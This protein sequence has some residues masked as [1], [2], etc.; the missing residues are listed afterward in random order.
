MA[1]N[2]EFVE[3]VYEQFSELEHIPYRKMFVEYVFYYNRKIFGNIYD[4]GSIIKIIASD[5]KLVPEYKME[6]SSGGE[7]LVF[8]A[9]NLDNKKFLKRL[10]IETCSKANLIK[11]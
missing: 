3:F 9:K 2:S 8:L 1:L 6:P 7:K 11:V 10:V 4:S 5:K